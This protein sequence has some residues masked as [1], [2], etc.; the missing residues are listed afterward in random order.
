M[1][2]TPS[3]RFPLQSRVL[4]YHYPYPLVDKMTFVPT[5]ALVVYPSPPAPPLDN[6]DHPNSPPRPT[7]VPRPWSTLSTGP[8][9]ME[10][11]SLE[12]DGDVRVAP[13]CV[14][15]PGALRHPVGS[16]R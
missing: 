3:P 8:V 7:P 4:K 12:H 9:G 11:P 6:P 14:P 1:P 13:D 10:I 2:P 15:R 5:S 16:S